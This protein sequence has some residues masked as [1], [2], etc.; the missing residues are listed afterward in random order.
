MNLDFEILRVDSTCISETTFAN[1]KQ[2]TFLNELIICILLAECPLGKLLYPCI[3][4]SSDPVHFNDTSILP[5][6]KQRAKKSGRGLE[7]KNQLV[8]NIADEHVE[9]LFSLVLRL[10]LSLSKQ[11]Q[12]SI[13]QDRSKKIV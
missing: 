12:R 4:S 8:R 9:A 2:F 3:T 1:I 11:S 13:L 6:G 10:L 7:I 5:S